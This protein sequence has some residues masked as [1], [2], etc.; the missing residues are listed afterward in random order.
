MYYIS[1]PDQIFNSLYY[2][3]LP[4]QIFNNLYYI[5]LPDQI[6]NSL[7]YISL[8]DQIVKALSKQRIIYKIFLQN[9]QNLQNYLQKTIIHDITY[10]R[11]RWGPSHNGAKELANLYTIGLLSYFFERLFL[12]ILN[13][14]LDE[15]LHR[16]GIL[17]MSDPY[18]K[19][20]F[21]I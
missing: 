4:D 5:S 15:I 9:L 16:K 13:S 6:F 18:L 12:F 1:L 11:H 20:G 21:S 7:Y 10:F 14:W 3:S 2:I 8:P 19:H 17:K